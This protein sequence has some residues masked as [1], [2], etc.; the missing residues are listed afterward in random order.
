[1]AIKKISKL[2]GFL[3]GA[4]VAVFIFC[5]VLCGIYYMSYHGV[6][7]GRSNPEGSNAVWARHSWVGEQRTAGEFDEFAAM[8]KRNSIT[9]VFVHVGPLNGFGSIEDGKYA[10]A[11]SMVRNMRRRV[12]GVRF[13]A[14][15]GQ[16]EKRGGGPLD[17]SNAGVRENII[18]A[19]KEFL[20]MG[21]DGIHYNIEPV[22]NGDGNFLALLDMAKEV[23]TE[24]RKTLSVSGF[25]LELLSGSERA[26]RIIAKRAALWDED[27]YRQVAA[28]VD[29]VAVMMYDTILPADWLYAKYVE[30]ETS[31]LLG[32]L[33][34]G[35]TVFIGVPTYEHRR[36]TRHYRIENINSALRGIL[37]ATGRTENVLTSNLGVAVYAEWT[38]DEDEWKIFRKLWLNEAE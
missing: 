11:R 38:T 2:V 23:V 18:A 26:V 10:H 27:Y 1:M 5:A 9:D 12:P 31:A 8:L 14:W 29:Q 6:K 37:M 22:Y 28:R 19:S 36:P 32:L 25:Q 24:R 33:G 17:L 4:G 3:L 34:S 35:T 7:P 30:W 21:F 20:D 13:Q 15:I 16:V